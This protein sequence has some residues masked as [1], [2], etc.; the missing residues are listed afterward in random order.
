MNNITKH[1]SLKLYLSLMNQ[2][3]TYLVTGDQ[4]MTKK[5]RAQWLTH[6]TTVLAN[7][8][9]VK[10]DFATPETLEHAQ[11]LISEVRR[12]LS[13]QLQAANDG[14][15]FAYTQEDDKTNSTVLSMKEV[16][17][18]LTETE[19]Q[20]RS[21]EITNRALKR[22]DDQALLDLGYTRAEIVQLKKLKETGVAGFP[23]TTVD[24]L[25]VKVLDLRKLLKRKKDQLQNQS[26]NFVCEK[27]TFY[28][29]REEFVIDFLAGTPLT[30]VAN[31][32]KSYAFVYNEKDDVWCRK[33]TRHSKIKCH[34]LLDKLNLLDEYCISSDN[35]D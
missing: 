31:L 2:L 20:L 23:K 10:C 8:E 24:Y 17:D 6:L 28:E 34:D 7:F 1:V 26:I 12:L 35:N 27:F 29:E 5:D 18:Q 33:V 14:L 22:G 32:V 3:E 11:N 13:S 19:Y 15:E 25:S 16:E 9:T 30:E 21:V 4:E